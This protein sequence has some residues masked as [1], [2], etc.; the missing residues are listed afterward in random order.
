MLSWRALQDPRYRPATGKGARGLPKGLGVK[1]DRA[2]AGICHAILV[3]LIDV[4]F[5]LWY[6]LGHPHHQGRL[7][8]A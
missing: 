4:V 1:V 5:D 8:A 7:L 6:V 3:D 2:A